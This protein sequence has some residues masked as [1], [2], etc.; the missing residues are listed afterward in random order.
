MH[1]EQHLEKKKLVGI[2]ANSVITL[3]TESLII[4]H[5]P[6][7]ATIIRKSVMIYTK[8]KKCQSGI[9][10]KIITVESNLE[11]KQTNKQKNSNKDI[12][13]KIH[14]SLVFS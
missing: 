6:L 8:T 14:T 2:K 5:F 4:C 1:L 10:S 9:I 3:A 11:N 7:P 13:H 12:N